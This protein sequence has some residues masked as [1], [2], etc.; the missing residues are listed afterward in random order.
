M[1]IRQVEL[2]SH[3][4]VALVA[5][6]FGRPRARLGHPLA[7]KGHLS[8]SGRK[9]VGRFC[10]AAR[11][12][13]QAARAVARLTPGAQRVGSLGNESRMVGRREAAVK[14]L[15]TLFAFL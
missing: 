11:L 10:L 8:T 9:R 3:L 2:S 15:V 4:S 1:V 5:D 7:R 14:L 6:R 12:G 13:M